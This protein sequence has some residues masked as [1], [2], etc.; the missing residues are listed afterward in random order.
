MKKEVKVIQDV[1]GHADIQTTLG[2]YGNVTNNLRKKEFES[3]G[4]YFT[5]IENSQPSKGAQSLRLCSCLA[6]MFNNDFAKKCEIKN[7]TLTVWHNMSR[8]ILGILQKFCKM[9]VEAML[10]E[11]K[12]KNYKS[13]LDETSF[14]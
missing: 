9:E 14:L 8:I 1:L 7:D 4:E 11:F 12:T 6:K 13:F 5:K 10:L 3:V 2:I